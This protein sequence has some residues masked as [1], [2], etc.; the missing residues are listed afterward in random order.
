VE[1]QA[2]RIGAKAMAAQTVSGKAIFELFNTVLALA[3]IVI[4]RKNGTAAA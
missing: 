2:E 3:T 4:E 1:Q